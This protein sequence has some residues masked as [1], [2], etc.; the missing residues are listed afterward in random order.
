M[1][2]FELSHEKTRS[3]YFG[4]LHLLSQHT[5]TY[6]SGAKA[7]KWWSKVVLR[8]QEE[9]EVEDPNA[10]IEKTYGEN[11]AGG[12]P[13]PAFAQEEYPGDE[14]QEY[15]EYGN[16]VYYDPYYSVSLNIWSTTGMLNLAMGF[17]QAYGEDQPSTMEWG[18]EEVKP[19]YEAT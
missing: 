17:L 4:K 3:N 15:D 1:S 7:G 19:R 16:P 13:Q 6:A 11:E 8:R 9:G 5:A 14:Y 12:A 2:T 10:I 18:P